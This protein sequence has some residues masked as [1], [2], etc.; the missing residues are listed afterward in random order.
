[1]AEIK[2]HDTVAIFDFDGTITQKNTTVPFLKFLW[3]YYFA[4]KF[5]TKLPSAIAYQ[6]QL[7]DIDQLNSA[8][9]KTFLKNLSRDFLYTTGELFS[10]RILPGLVKPS[11]FSR[12][13]W[14]KEQGHYCILAT[15]AYNIYVDY[16][17]RQTGFDDIA[18]TRIEF[19][20]SNQA[21]GHLE[22]KSCNGPEK[23]RRVLELIPEAKTS[24]AYGDSTGDKELLEFA[25][26]PYYREFK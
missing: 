20:E 2:I 23:L 21:T 19:N 26:Y 14:H 7:I 22:G 8:I 4:W 17:A 3:G 24:Y 12:L 6:L 11:A 5:M 9:A 1:M 16:W 13:Q 15:S 25:T 18:S 10:N